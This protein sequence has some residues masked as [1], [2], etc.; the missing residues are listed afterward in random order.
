MD[1]KHQ[2]RLEIIF[3]GKLQLFESNAA[4]L[5]CDSTIHQFPIVFEQD[6]Q[7]NSNWGRKHQ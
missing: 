3:E 2:P 6:Q 7:S 4:Y 5:G 1:G